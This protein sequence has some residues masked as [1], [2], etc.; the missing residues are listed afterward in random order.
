MIPEGS[1]GHSDHNGSHGIVAIGHQHDPKWW[2]RALA[3]AWPS[4][5][6]G[7]T[8]INTVPGCHV[9]KK[10]PMV[11]PGVIFYGK[12]DYDKWDR[13]RDGMLHVLSEKQI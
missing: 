1:V 5:V 6:S 4:T 9:A 11:Q 2:S 7:A 12:E 8:E 10:T 13:K 3:S